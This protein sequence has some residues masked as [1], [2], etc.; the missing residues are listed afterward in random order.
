MMPTDL[1]YIHI[2]DLVVIS[3]IWLQRRRLLSEEKEKYGLLGSD[4]Y[5][6]EVEILSMW[7][8]SLCIPVAIIIKGLGFRGDKYME[9]IIQT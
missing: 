9:L 5:P 2:D 4:N 3:S 6:N 8:R 1:A 7:H